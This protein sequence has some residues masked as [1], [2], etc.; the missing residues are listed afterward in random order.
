MRPSLHSSP[1]AW[2]SVGFCLE[3]ILLIVME[4]VGGGTLT[5]F[6]SFHQEAADMIGLAAKMEILMGTARGLEY[7][8][9]FE[10]A[11]VLHRDIKSENILLTEELLPRVADL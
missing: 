7:L 11:P 4:F 2:N 9:C 1:R 3:P 5:D 10:E 6:I 8:H